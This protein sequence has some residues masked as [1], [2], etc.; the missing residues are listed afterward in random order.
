MN[1]EKRKDSNLK[2]LNVEIPQEIIT[3]IKIAAIKRNVPMGTL[4]LRAL[5]K[6]LAIENGY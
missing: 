2:Q 4:V 6:S 3:Q 5:I 1:N